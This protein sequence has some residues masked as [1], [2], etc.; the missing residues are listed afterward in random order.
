MGD[1]LAAMRAERN[2]AIADA[3]NMRRERDA[4][5]MA[6]QDL[7]GRCNVLENINAE[8]KKKLAGLEATA[9]ELAERIGRLENR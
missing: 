8:L 9:L 4:A 7:Q 3:V 5:I 2:E 6:R 1:E